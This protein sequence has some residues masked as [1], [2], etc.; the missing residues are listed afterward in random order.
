MIFMKKWKL[1]ILAVVCG[2]SM[3]LLS[4]CILPI[5]IPGRIDTSPFVSGRLVD[6]STKKPIYGASIY[7]KVPGS[8]PRAKIVSK[9]DGTFALG[10][11]KHLYLIRVIT[12]CPEYY[13]PPPP[14]YAD[15]LEISSPGYPSKQIYLRSIYEHTIDEKID[16]GDIELMSSAAHKETEQQGR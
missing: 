10:P 1:I 2:I 8:L 4:M 13:L 5:P 14:P 11:E 12:P 3:L 7:F 15:T 9:A 6:K 16:L